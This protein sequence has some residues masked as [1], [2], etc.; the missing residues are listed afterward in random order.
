M[1][2][3]HAVAVG[4]LAAGLLALPVASS[5]AAAPTSNCSH[6]EYPPSKPKLTLT[7]SPSMVTAGQSSTAMGSFTQ[8]KCYIRGAKIQLQKRYLING[9]PSGSFKTFTTVTTDNHG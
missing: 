4:A 7:L 8:N 3:R 9:K 5:Q 1:S 2:V 6:P